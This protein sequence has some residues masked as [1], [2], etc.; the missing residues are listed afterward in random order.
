MFGKKADP[1]MTYEQA[2]NKYLGKETTKSCVDCGCVVVTEKLKYVVACR[3]FEY[4]KVF[5]C[6]RCKPSYDEV[7]YD[8]F[9]GPKKYFQRIPEYLVEVTKEGKKIVEKKKK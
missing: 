1:V 5:Y 4:K 6:A 3:I 9:G 7:R 8:Y 2:Q